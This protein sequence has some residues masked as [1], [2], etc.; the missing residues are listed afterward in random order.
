MSF[1]DLVSSINLIT[2]VLINIDTN[3]GIDIIDI[4]IDP[5]TTNSHLEIRE[6]EQSPFT[7][8]RTWSSSFLCEW[9]GL[10]TCCFQEWTG[11]TRKRSMRTGNC[12]TPFS[13]GW[14]EGR[15]V[16]RWVWTQLS[17]SFTVTLSH[18]LLT[19]VCWSHDSKFVSS[20]LVTDV[21]SMWSDPQ[22]QMWTAGLEQSA[23]K[24]RIN[25]VHSQFHFVSSSHLFIKCLITERVFT[26]R[27]SSGHQPVGGSACLL[28]SA[29]RPWRLSPSGCCV[30]EL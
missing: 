8:I 4:W 18:L 7:W 3:V 11:S 1:S 27:Y 23:F 26:I 15:N 9:T 21:V 16:K 14:A 19:S 2:L 20:H 10:W 12:Q 29:I 5:P 30:A 28:S 22:R 25:R 6:K 13:L 24:G 17:E